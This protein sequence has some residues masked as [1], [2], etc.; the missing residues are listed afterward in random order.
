MAKNQKARID[1]Q[2]PHVECDTPPSFDDV[3]EDELAFTGNYNK[4]TKEGLLSC[5]C[6]SALANGRAPF[7]INFVSHPEIAA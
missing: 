4:T 3:V 7:D 2:F 1:R 5:Y 6:R